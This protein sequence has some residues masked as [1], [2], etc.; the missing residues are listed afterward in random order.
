M[1]R[2]GTAR[3]VDSSVERPAGAPARHDRHAAPRQ[4]QR[5]DAAAGGDRHARASTSPGVRFRAWS[6]PSALHPTIGVHAPLTFD[7]V[8]TWAGRAIG[9]CVYHVAHPG[10]RNYE[11]FPVNA[12][13]AQGST[14][15]QVLGART[16]A[17]ARARSSRSRAIPRFPATLDLRFAAE[18]LTPT[19]RR[20]AASLAGA[21]AAIAADRSPSGHERESKLLAGYPAPGRRALRR[22]VRRAPGQPRAVHWSALLDHLLEALGPVSPAGASA[23]GAATAARERRHLQRLR[24]SRRASRGRGTSTCCR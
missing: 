15:R 9:G 7:I 3:Y 10:G 21:P 13:E 20:A 16:H 17:G 19:G 5:P 1:S 6:P 24:R 18:A 2:G 14:T 8:D 22:T 23:R 12:N 4:L 11:T